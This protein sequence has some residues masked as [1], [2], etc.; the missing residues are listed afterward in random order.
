M[1]TENYSVI[2]RRGSP[3]EAIFFLHKNRISSRKRKA[4]AMQTLHFAMTPEMHW[5]NCRNNKIIRNL[6]SFNVISCPSS[7]ASWT[8]LPHR[9]KKEL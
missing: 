8:I 6:F 2:A 9:E 4:F 1:T 5:D 3:D 7:L